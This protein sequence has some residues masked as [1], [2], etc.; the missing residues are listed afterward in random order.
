MSIPNTLT[1]YIN[2]RITGY[3][4]LTYKP[5]MTLPN[6]SGNN[7]YFDP[8]VKLSKS[9]IQSVPKTENKEKEIVAQFFNK[10][11]FESMIN[12][13]LSSI[14]SGQLLDKP[15]YTL[16][17][18][19]KES[20]KKNNIN[21]NIRLT[22]E[23]LFRPN[24]I[25][26]IGG[27][28]YTI[29]SYHW[30]DGDWKVDTKLYT[31][32]N[33]L[34]NSSA[35]RRNQPIVIQ[36]F[37]GPAAPNNYNLAQGELN[38]LDKD[39]LEG[40]SFNKN[41]YV[42]QP[43]VEEKKPNSG[44]GKLIKSQDVQNGKKKE[45]I[46]K[47][48]LIVDDEKTKIK[49]ETGKKSTFTTFKDYLRKGKNND[50]SLAKAKEEP[51]NHDISVAEAKEAS[52][53]EELFEE[54][55]K[56]K[57]PK[58]LPKEGIK[59]SD[60]ESKKYRKKNIKNWV[61]DYMENNLYTVQ[62]NEGGGNCFFAVIR[63][64]FASIGKI[65]TVDKLRELLS[66]EVTEELFKGYKGNYNA[67]YN[68]WSKQQEDLA[69]HENNPEKTLDEMNEI[70][71]LKVEIL[72]TEA[73]INEFA[74]MENINDVDQMK[75]IIKTCEFWADT[76]AISTL[77]RVMNIK[78]ILMSSEAFKV[79]DYAN[80]LQ[81]GQM[82]DPILENSCVFKPEYYIIFE[83]T[84]DHYKLIGY[85]WKQIFTFDELPYELIKLI[86]ERCMVKNS[87]LFSLIPEFKKF[88][89][90][91]L[92]F[93]GKKEHGVRN[94]TGGQNEVTSTPSIPVS[95]N[96]NINQ[97]IIPEA[98]LVI[99]II[100]DA[101]PVQEEE[102]TNERQ[103]EEQEPRFEREEKK[104]IPVRETPTTQLKRHI[105]SMFYSDSKLG[106][107]IVV[108]L[109]L[110]PG[111]SIPLSKRPSIACEI[112]RE[113]IKEALAEFR[114]VVYRPSPQN[115]L[116]TYTTKKNDVPKPSAPPMTQKRYGGLRKKRFTMKRGKNRKNKK[117]KKSKKGKTKEKK[118]KRTLKKR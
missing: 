83:H 67:I 17:A 16:N 63:D 33:T 35:Y 105:N 85:K 77:E 90:I 107:F 10:G 106:Y 55:E 115:K 39:V 2:T 111:T 97:S 26:T 12:R 31:M 15:G 69:I 11:Q 13:S 52:L 110:Y 42:Y 46:V 71:E 118:R 22:L 51:I 6:N 112:Q 68:F 114:G 72:Q 79:K 38:L 32:N 80:V 45:G 100:N 113:R 61:E 25:I 62:D 94:I 84:G 50:I 91:E 65:T 4:K 8:L 102:R 19:L 3:Q 28:P 86:V 7:V 82:N 76:W 96:I 103:M 59:Q 18:K 24:N 1:I 81:C 53:F 21:Q 34:V 20:I 43:I 117:N 64:A 70:E 14:F 101:Q 23:T 40:D 48:E 98:K 74:F 95:S 60:I 37:M 92:G 116:S 75:E 36:N 104:S 109:E 93:K 99:P 49:D 29:I 73:L 27:K 88:K 66:N 89:E 44:V 56:F 9:V 30:D 41:D 78:F 87:G 47:G 58:L 57:K 108:D 54:N 5:S